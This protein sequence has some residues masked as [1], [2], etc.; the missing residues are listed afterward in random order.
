M[1]DS[2]PNLQTLQ[3]WL[4]AVIMHP[5]G[6]VHGMKS[7]AALEHIQVEPAGL[8]C[9]VRPSNSQ[10]S[11]DR[12]EIYARAYY[13]RLLECLKA[14]YPVLAECLDRELFDEFALGY[15][16]QNP[17]RSYTLG[18]LGAAFP[19][20]LRATCPSDTAQ[21][22][23]PWFLVDLA[24]LEW[25]VNE[26]FDGPGA[27]DSERLDAVKLA[28]TSSEDLM[29]RRLQVVPCVR[30]RKFAFPVHEYYRSI[31][32]GQKAEPPAAREIGLLFWRENYVVKYREISWAQF[33]LLS[34]I[35]A[36][37]TLREAI[38]GVAKNY[39]GTLEQLAIEFQRWFHQWGADGIFL[40][41]PTLARI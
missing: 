36:G 32:D 13:A 14:E 33:D 24:A 31:R 17:S 25:I 8:D 28:Q 12:L 10:S 34:T 11:L 22:S 39:E 26:V 9:V 38:E 5:G 18:R 30:L 23:I 20:Y 35:M 27:E 3:K 2:E 41:A 4:Q 29:Q 19:D 21:G 7:G 40:P 15:L 1:P 6:V 37:A 16:E